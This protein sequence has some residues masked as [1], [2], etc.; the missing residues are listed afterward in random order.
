MAMTPC[1]L[2]PPRP[3]RFDDVVDQNDPVHG[4]TVFYRN[5]DSS[6]CGEIRLVCIKAEPCTVSQP[7]TTPFG[8]QAQRAT[9]RRR[10][11]M[12]VG[13][14][15]ETGPLIL[16]SSSL[17]RTHHVALELTGNTTSCDGRP[18]PPF[19]AAMSRGVR[20]SR[21]RYP[22]V[23]VDGEIVTSG[24]SVESTVDDYF[25]VTATG[26]HTSTGCSVSCIPT[27]RI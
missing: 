19:S 27:D 24:V 3:I 14:Q 17:G 12:K 22:I 5:D 23:G 13:G 11:I 25:Y 8:S 21:S 4:F 26:A 15:V 9:P 18:A 6:H 2:P 7:A 20:A 1:R 10:Q 16:E